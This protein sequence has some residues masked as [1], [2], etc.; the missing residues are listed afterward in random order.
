ML[1]LEAV[2][3]KTR[4]E[5]ITEWYQEV[6]PHAAKYIK[7]HGGD[8]EVTRE[9][10]QESVVLYYEK[11]VNLNFEHDVNQRAYLMGI[12]KNQWFK[13]C[14]KN[15][16]FSG[17]ESIELMEEQTQKPLSKKLLDYLKQSGEKCMDLL[18]A[19]YYE[20][21]TM[22][23][24]SDRFSYSSERSATVQKFKCLEKVR[25]Q[26]KQKALTYEDFL[27]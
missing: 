24:L 8:L 19:F 21:L 6:F 20:K 1:I 2:N 13:H 14:K 15:A 12:V 16:R 27:D 25:N 23:Q 3:T 9:V 26:I 18:Q 22:K 10:F 17:L 5:V 7:K 4:S 11:L